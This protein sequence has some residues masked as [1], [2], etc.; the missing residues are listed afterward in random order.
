ML[1]TIFDDPEILVSLVIELY[2]WC[3]DSS[4]GLQE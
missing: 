3:N 1:I 4:M 2:R